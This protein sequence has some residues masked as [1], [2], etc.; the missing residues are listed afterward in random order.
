MWLVFSAD[1]GDIKFPHKMPIIEETRLSVNLIARFLCVMLMLLADG[2][3][4]LTLSSS[5]FP[6]TDHESRPIDFRA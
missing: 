3:C 2:M 4:V 1:N 5:Q 6:L